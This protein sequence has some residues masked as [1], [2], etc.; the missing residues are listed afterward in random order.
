LQE[1]L[2]K[3]LFNLFKIKL[4]KWYPKFISGKNLKIYTYKNGINDVKSSIITS[5]KKQY[6]QLL[7]IYF[8]NG[9]Y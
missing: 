8:V 2:L 7:F 5:T 4:P 9:I 1:V 6:F 3:L